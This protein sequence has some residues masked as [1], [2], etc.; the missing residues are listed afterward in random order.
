MTALALASSMGITPGAPSPSGFP[1]Y[2]GPGGLPEGYANPPGSFP[3]PSPLPPGTSFTV[4]L[5]ADG[6]PILD[7]D[8]NPVY[9]KDSF[10]NP[11][12]R[13]DEQLGLKEGME[14][15]L[16]FKGRFGPTAKTGAEGPGTNIE[17]YGN[18]YGN[19]AETNNGY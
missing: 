3:I 13:F 12:L 16:N 10:G 19:G 1:T 15:F 2:P 14:D 18:G 6:N 5:D 7:A 8:G 9:E 17:H 11:V 4:M